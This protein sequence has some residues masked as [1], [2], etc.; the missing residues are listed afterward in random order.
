MSF[1]KLKTS[2]G[3]DCSK[4]TDKTD[5][6]DA[7]YLLIQLIK[8]MKNKET[9]NPR[10]IK[11]NFKLKQIN[12]LDQWQTT[13][14]AIQG[15]VSMKEIICLHRWNEKRIR[16]VVQRILELYVSRREH[17]ECYTRSR[18]F[19]SFHVKLLHKR[20][21]IRSFQFFFKFNQMKCLYNMGQAWIYFSM[22]ASI[23]WGIIV[24]SA[25]AWMQF[26]TL[27]TFEV[28]LSEY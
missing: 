15:Y 19:I 5:F 25:Y 2:S 16:I 9:L 13:L 18:H 3:V 23:K 14:L 12:K 10:N 28:V 22:N 8:Y 4:W 11:V 27:I 1:L 21:D 20:N 24:N 26:F 7:S 17:K 6:I